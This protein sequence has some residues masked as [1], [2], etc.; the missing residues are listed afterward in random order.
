M[1]E[2][3]D[4]FKFIL[5]G[6]YPCKDHLHFTVLACCCTIVNLF[7]VCF[8]V[9]IWLL[10]SFGCFLGGYLL[11][12]VKRVYF[13][14]LYN[15]LSMESHQPS[16]AQPSPAQPCLILHQVKIISYVM[17]VYKLCLCLWVWWTLTKQAPQIRYSLQRQIKCQCHVEKGLT[18]LIKYGANH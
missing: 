15:G 2:E 3:L 10:K 7:C 6:A 16:P 18:Y 17:Y 11:V 9:A 8:H 12:Q 5:S 4:I 14:S 13:P 1:W